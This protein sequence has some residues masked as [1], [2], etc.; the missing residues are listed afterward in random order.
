[1]PLFA[2]VRRGSWFGAVRCGAVWRGAVWRGAVRFGAVWRG[3]VVSKLFLAVW[4]LEWA[5]TVLNA[6]TSNDQ[7]LFSVAIHK[8]NSKL[9]GLPSVDRFWA[10]SD[11]RLHVIPV[12]S[13][14]PACKSLV[15]KERNDPKTKTKQM[16]LIIA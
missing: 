14:H 11:K 7:Q 16:S 10:T 6:D 15:L 9:A 3:A 5:K 12:D 13:R 1:L 2:A 4:K 8:S